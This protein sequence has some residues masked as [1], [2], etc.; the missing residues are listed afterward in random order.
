LKSYDEKSSL[1]CSDKGVEEQ[2]GKSMTS[3]DEQDER[4]EK[5]LVRD[6]KTLFEERKPSSL[7]KLFIHT[8]FATKKFR[9]IWSEWWSSEIPPQLEVDMIPVFGDVADQVLMVGIE[10]EFYKGQTKSFCDGLQQILSFGIFGFDSLV[11]W[12]IFAETMENSKIEQYVRAN[13]EIVDGLDLPVIYCATKLIGKDTFEFFAP[14]HYYSSQPVAP[15]YFLASLRKCCAE[16]RNP[17]LDKDEIERRK[18]MLKVILK[19]PV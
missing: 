19:I 6:L 12:H 2:G 18:R 17:L 14:S 15:E 11:L 10:V 9:D 13:Q 1:R 3:L 5:A 7:K 16:K 8:N 4:T